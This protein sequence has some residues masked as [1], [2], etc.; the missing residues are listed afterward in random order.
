MVGVLVGDGVGVNVRVG[1]PKGVKVR[2]GERVTV[3]VE[4]EVGVS[5]GP[6]NRATACRAGTPPAAASPRTVASSAST[7]GTNS[8][9][10]PR[11]AL[12]YALSLRFMLAPSPT[13]LWIMNFEL[14]QPHSKIKNHNS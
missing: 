6:N 5:S 13:T 9:P 2:V 4:V 14:F 3:A 10:R 8:R 11:F 7:P 12:A 1:V